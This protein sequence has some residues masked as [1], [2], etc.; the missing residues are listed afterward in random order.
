MSTPGESQPG[1]RQAAL[2]TRSALLCSDIHLSNDDP[3]L[4]DRFLGWLERESIRLKPES[5]IILGDCFD[6][7]IG[8]DLLD[9]AGPNTCETRLVTCLQQLAQRGHAL[10]IMHGNR[11]FL[12]DNQFANACAATLLRDPC[13]LS[14]DSGLKI[15]LTHGDQ[16]C[17][18][19]T[20]YQA[21][22]RQ[23]RTGPWQTD[24]LS[25]P[26]SQRQEIARDLR[27][28]SEHEKSVKSMAI[29]DITDADAAFLTDQ[30][31]ADL[32]LHGH[33][34]RPGRSVMSN[35]KLRWVL[36]DWTPPHSGGLW[37]DAAGIQ[38]V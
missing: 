3:E 6:A 32:L 21:F 8:D 28:Q 24:F 1:A 31:G 35:G 11:D 15:L 25:K 19:D 2:G 18:A 36:P 37:V 27:M 23:L 34:H 14:I 33:T 7:W 12:L 30:L 20:D 22:R 10:Y 9:T 17:T 13:V 29:M 4:T 26:L 5:I 16:L 38:A